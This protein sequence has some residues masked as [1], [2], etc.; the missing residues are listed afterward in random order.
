MSDEKIIAPTTSDYSPNPQLS[1]LG[2]K[3][4]LE[5]KESCLKQDK[6]TYDHGKVANIYIVYEISKNFNISSYST[7]ENCLFDAVS[8]TKNTDI[9]SINI[10]DVELDLIDLHFFHT[11]VVE[12]GEM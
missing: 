5:F 1:Y 9:D 8:F 4:R 6:N 10:L 12:L 7:L 11:L 2:T 3:T